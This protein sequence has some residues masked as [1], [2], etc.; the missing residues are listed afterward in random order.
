M[1]KQLIV[2]TGSNM[3]QLFVSMVVT[4][5]M[6]PIY[7][8]MMGHHDYGLREMV[9][10]IVGYMGMLDLGM[11]PTVSRFASMHNALRDRESLLIVYSSSLVFLTIVG[12]F[13]GAFFWVW[14]ISFPEV[15]N[16]EGGDERVKYTL[17][18]LLVGAQIFFSFPMFV[19]ESYL[20]GLQRYYIKNMINIAFTILIA[21]ICYITMTP[22]N[23]LVLLVGLG[24]LF[25]AIR[26]LLFGGMLMRPAIG[27][28][29]PNFRYFS[30]GKLR[31]MLSFGFKSFIQGAASRVER[32]SDRIVIG[33]I[34]GPAA[35]PVYTIPSTL[36]GYI[37]SITMTLTHAFMPLFSDL[38]ARNQHG[39]IK[40]IYMLSSKLVVGLIIP[41]AVGICIVGGPFIARWMPGEFDPALV[42]AILV[43]L[44][45]YLCVPMLN[46]FV[47]R[48]LTAI[49][50]HGIFAKVAPP[51]ALVNVGL[52]IW[53]VYEFGVI[54][55]ALGSVFP[56]F[57]V[58]PIFL[59]AVA[60][61]IGITMLEYVRS[62]ILPALFPVSIMGGGLIWWRYQYGLETYFE[63]VGAVLVSAMIYGGI[64]WTAALNREER[65]FFLRVI[66]VK[67][68]LRRPTVKNKV[69]G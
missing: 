40:S 69:K 27:S 57:V 10:A 7:L 50:K 55:A 54:G 17:F 25:Q 59:K 5:V 16:P 64:Y 66:P 2:N 11:R 51:A 3:A 30:R 60:G 22:Q 44:V 18:L 56:V 23:A 9:L 49:N 45:L 42:D 53:F 31:E 32:M 46:P 37:S 35:I 29:Y 28:I 20:E 1:L 43:L 21:L 19:A 48:Y 61:Q 58:M 68:L 36:V 8:K 33:S 14:A 15:L 41:M 24:A 47:S 63:I 26:L 12:T 39:R 65:E 4:F 52:S 38:S 67:K 13:L 34:L 6:A 62:V